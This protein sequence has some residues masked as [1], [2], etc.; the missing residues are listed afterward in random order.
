MNLFLGFTTTQ[1]GNCSAQNKRAY[2]DTQRAYDNIRHRCCVFG[3]RCH[4]HSLGSFGTFWR[5]HRRYQSCYIGSALSDRWAGILVSGMDWRNLK[6]G[7][8]FWHVNC[9]WNCS[10]CSWICCPKVLA[11]QAGQRRVLD[12][13]LC[14]FTVVV[15]CNKWSN[16]PILWDSLGMGGDNGRST[17]AL[18][19]NCIYLS[20]IHI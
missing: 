13:K 9:L 18:N 3:L 8:F 15:F 17:M 10:D 14:M 2:G 19:E 20:L 4:V 7:L 1:I 11:A 5:F 12:L 6:L 16:A